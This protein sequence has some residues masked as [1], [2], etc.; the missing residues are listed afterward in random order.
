[1]D[2][3]T[4]NLGYDVW[5]IEDIPSNTTSNIYILGKKYSF[6]ELDSIR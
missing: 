6:D 5:E 1:M 3:L 4:E 2:L